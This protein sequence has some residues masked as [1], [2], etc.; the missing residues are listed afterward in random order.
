MGELFPRT[1]YF[2]IEEARLLLAAVL[3][4]VQRKVQS[5]PLEQRQIR[6]IEFSQFSSDSVTTAG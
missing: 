6:C 2:L 4:I 3:G 1:L 5:F